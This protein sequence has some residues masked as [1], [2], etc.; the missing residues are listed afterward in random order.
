MHKKK[1]KKLENTLHINQYSNGHWYNEKM[2][3]MKGKIISFPLKFSRS[4]KVIKS[5]R[6]I[7]S[8]IN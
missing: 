4:D 8:A 2:A 1:K 3:K 6:N 5:N 7:Q